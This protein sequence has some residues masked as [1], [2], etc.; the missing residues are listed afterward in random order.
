MTKQELG[1]L[2]KETSRLEDEE[3]KRL[4]DEGYQFIGLDGPID[5]KYRDMRKELFARYEREKED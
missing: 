1:E 2:L 3:R 5:K 4:K